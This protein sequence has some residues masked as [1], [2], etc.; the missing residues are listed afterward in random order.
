[1]GKTKSKIKK[2]KRKLLGKAQI[3]GTIS[4]KY[5]IKEKKVHG[6]TTNF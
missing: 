4:K 1:M 6:S 2:K 3:N 5:L